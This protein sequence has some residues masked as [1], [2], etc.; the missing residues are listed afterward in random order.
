MSQASIGQGAGAFSGRPRTD[1]VRIAP[2]P[3]V[4]EEL[5]TLRD[6]D[7]KMASIVLAIAGIACIALTLVS[8]AFIGKYGAKHA[9]ASYHVG[10]ICALGISLGSLGWVMILNLVNAQWHVVMRRILERA[11]SLIWVG[12]AMVLVTLLVDVF[13]GGTLF[14]WMDPAYVAGDPIYEHK[15]GYLNIPFLLIRA[16]VYI[17]LWFVLARTL[18]RWS[19]A[20]DTTGDNG[21]TNKA[22]T[23]SAPGM[24]AFALTTAFAAFDWMMSLDFHWFSTMYPVYF[25]AGNQMSAIAMLILVVAYLQT[26]GKLVGLVTAEHR[27]DM[28]KLLL[29]FCVFWAYVCFSQ[30]FLIWYSQIPEETAYYVHRQQH[31][32]Q[33]VG[34]LLAAGHF[35]LPF[36]F[37]LFR[38]VKKSTL[39]LSIA[40]AWLMVMHF[41]DVYYNIRPQ[42]SK[43]QGGF[44]WLLIDITGAFG[45][46]LL[47]GALLLRSL[48]KGPL[49]PVKDPKLSLS[50]S[51]KNYV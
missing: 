15:S 27:H 21:L 2:P 33:Y 8:S 37:L 48:T 17:S 18:T 5:V 13:T 14:K 16:V 49:I 36:V 23:L 10:A 38:A 47:L 31:G 3:E 26:K 9:L 25:F 32:W 50:L 43:T 1:A 7:V 28:G 30:Y 29:A 45:P 4:D 35:V 41:V 19:T 39:L 6:R 12:A 51:H 20:Q 11:A 40:A 34:F 24:L 44:E 42:V 46:V 22:R